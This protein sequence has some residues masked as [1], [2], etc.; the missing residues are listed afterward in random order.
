MNYAS[1]GRRI[2]GF[3]CDLVTFI[4]IYWIYTLILK[5]LIVVDSPESAISKVILS[6]IFAILDM[7]L[8]QYYLKAS[9]GQLLLG[10][11]TLNA[12]NGEK[13]SFVRLLL[14]SIL[15]PV[16]TTAFFMG[17]IWAS[18]DSRKQTAHDKITGTIVIRKRKDEEPSEWPTESVEDAKKFR[19]MRILVLLVSLMLLVL[20][21]TVFYLLGTDEV[22]SDQAREMFYQEEVQIPAEENAYYW[23]NGFGLPKELDVIAT[24]KEW[25][26]SENERI[27]QYLDTGDIRFARGI[28][29]EKDLSL[30]E[31]DTKKF[32]KFDSSGVAYINE[33]KDQIFEFYGNADHF[34]SRYEKL[35][36]QNR[37]YT[38][39]LPSTMAQHINGIRLIRFQRIEKAWMYMNYLDG[40]R[41][42]TLE[43]LGKRIETS[44][45]LMTN[46]DVMLVRLMASVLID[47]QVSLLDDLMQAEGIP[48]EE[49]VVFT[50]NLKPLNQEERS[51]KNA[52]R[53]EAKLKLNIKDVF[54]GQKIESTNTHLIFKENSTANALA[55]C[56]QRAIEVSEMDG[57][58]FLENRNS[59]VPEPS[60]SQYVRNLYGTYLSSFDVTYLDY[61]AKGYNLNCYM[62]LL[63]AKAAI[64]AGNIDEAEL[65][66]FLFENRET[67]YNCFNEGPLEWDAEQNELFFTD[68]SK[69]A[70]K[71][72]NRVKINF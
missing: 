30:D 60:I 1:A 49:L 23:L 39:V 18:V 34:K 58:D 57:P 53:Y 50:L 61:A 37:F 25:V 52:L 46:S 29:I 68:P 44:R 15:I 55:E 40:N 35:G 28:V 69:Y 70:D 5:L 14:R 24:V 45:K 26:D 22:L 67:Y 38:E 62:M 71:D 43:I 16:S 21:P 6:L 31:I 48:S 7:V 51:L 59:I 41:R 42:E 12:Q 2:L 54:S 20:V 17:M 36:E 47:I 64:L 63:K 10:L 56:Y 13:V 33:H 11:Q 72:D 8:I 66:N 9:P 19:A 4:F 27:T 3:F 65:E 32:L